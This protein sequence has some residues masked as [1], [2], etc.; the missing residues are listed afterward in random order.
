[1]FSALYYFGHLGHIYDEVE[2]EVPT[3]AYITEDA[4]QFY[5][6]EDASNVYVIESA[7]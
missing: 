5:I 4:S 7:F 6:T 3:A 1:M 2:G